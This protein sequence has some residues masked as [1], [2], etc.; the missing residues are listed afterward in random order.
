MR[1]IC[2]ALLF[3]SGTM[4][5][6]QSAFA[7]AEQLYQ[8]EKY[9]K[10]LDA[11]I[12]LYEQDNENLKVVER[13]G[14]IAGHKK[15]YEE[16]MGFYKKLLNTQPY[17]ANYNFKYGGAMGLYA[18][19]VSKLKALGMLD[20]IKRHLKKAAELDPNHIETR[21][22]LSQIY[23][24]LPGI[25]GGSIKTSRSYADEL[26]KISP[27]DGHLAHGFIDEYQKEYD[28]AVISY[29]KAIKTGGS[30]LTYRKLAGV[31][32]EKLKNN[33]KALEV[34]KRAR[35]KYSDLQLSKDIAIL[36][37]RVK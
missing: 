24:E 36:E 32:Q 5:Y 18:K 22:A 37:T 11:F 25:V 8:E 23:C 3:L 1:N 27:V 34:L 6:G 16:A 28:D 33:K 17:N 31:Y 14:D 26:L 21:H 13:M 12:K 35:A 2:I 19:T 4:V 20:D 9:D 15:N 30:L 29:E 7:K 10:A